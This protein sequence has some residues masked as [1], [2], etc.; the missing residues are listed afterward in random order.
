MRGITFNFKND[1]G[2]NKGTS[3]KDLILII[4]REKLIDELDIQDHEKKL[5]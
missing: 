5:F 1:L 2:T 4:K 3:T